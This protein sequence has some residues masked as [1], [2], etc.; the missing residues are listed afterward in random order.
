MSWA[1]RRAQASASGRR[2][3][4]ISPTPALWGE[5]LERGRRPVVGHPGF[6]PRVLPAA[7]VERLL[8]GGE[9]LVGADDVH[10]RVDERQ[11][12]ERLR[13]VAQVPAR[14]GVDLLRVELQRRGVAEHLLAQLPGPPRLAD[15]LER[16]DEPEGADGERALLA[17]EPVVRLVRA[18]AQD[19]PV[20]RQLV[21]DRVDRGHHARVVGGQEAQQRHEQARRV[22]RVG[23]V[24]LG[25]DA[26]LVQ[27]V[28]EDVGV[29][30]VGLG[31][32]GLGLLVVA[33]QPCQPGA[34]VHRHPAHDLRG[35]EVLRARRA[36]PRCPRSGSRQYSMAHSTWWTMIG[37]TCSGS[38]SRV[39]VCR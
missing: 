7:R 35:G 11:V 6:D 27:A 31:L 12:R 2:T 18:V 22:E 21:V 14:A 33:A 4:S 26:A 1:A 34:A 10:D 37:H 39:F 30:R 17:L 15:L 36:P 28:G 25:E 23:V 38:W 13:E 19:Q 9:L 29:D 20:H 32:P 3:T 16:A 8:A 24:V 5:L